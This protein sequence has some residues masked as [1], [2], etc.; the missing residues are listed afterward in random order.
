MRTQAM[1]HNDDMGNLDRL[2]GATALQ[3][4]VK[5]RSSEWMRELISFVAPSSTAFPHFHL[6]VYANAQSRGLVQHHQR[7][8]FFPRQS[9][10]AH[11]RFSREQRRIVEY[12]ERKSTAA[13]QHVGTPRRA[14]GIEGA[15][16][17]EPAGVECGPIGRIECARRVDVCHSAA[18]RDGGGHELAHQ[19]R[20]P[21]SERAGDF[22]DSSPRHPTS[23]RGIERRDTGGEDFCTGLGFG[24][25]KGKAIDR[26]TLKHGE[27]LIHISF[28]YKGLR[29]TSRLA[30]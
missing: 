30:A 17:A 11:G 9:G 19:R 3:T 28:S 12:H 27:G 4:N 22:S 1:R 6:Q 24:C 7:R 8:R 20:F 21:G 15:D 16:N 14:R 23:K 25:D 10:E 26:E 29:F 18:P 13:K 2:A 5:G